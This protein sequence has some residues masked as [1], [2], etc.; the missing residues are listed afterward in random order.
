[1][2]YS[3]TS[4][5]LGLDL[6]KDAD[7]NVYHE[8][9]YCRSCCI[10]DFVSHKPLRNVLSSTPPETQCADRDLGQRHCHRATEGKEALSKSREKSNSISFLINAKVRKNSSCLV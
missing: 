5:E 9:K 2:T 6:M 4:I 1:M 7:S 3:T 8:A 10:R